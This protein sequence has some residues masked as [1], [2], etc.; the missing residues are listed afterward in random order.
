MGQFSDLSLA[1]A[2]CWPVLASVMLQTVKAGHVMLQKVQAG[3]GMASCVR[4]LRIP[5]FKAEAAPRPTRQVPWI[6]LPNIH[7]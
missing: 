5:Q 2:R 4:A 6:F 1:T 7:A 3:H